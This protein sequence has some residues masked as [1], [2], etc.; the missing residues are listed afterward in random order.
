MSG[1][2][3]RAG[4]ARWCRWRGGGRRNRRRG[5]RGRS[6]GG[7]HGGATTAQAGQFILGRSGA[8]I[9]GLAIPFHRTIT[10]GADIEAKFIDQAKLV[11]R[12]GMALCA[13]EAEPA[14]C[15]RVGAAGTE[16]LRIDQAEFVFGFGDAKLGRR[17]GPE[18]SLCRIPRHPDAAI[19]AARRLMLSSTASVVR[20]GG[21]WLPGVSFS[22]RGT[23][24]S[25]RGMKEPPD[26]NCSVAVR[27]TIV[28]S[29]IPRGTPARRA[30][31]FAASRASG[32]TP[33]TLHGDDGFIRSY[34][35]SNFRSA[36]T[37]PV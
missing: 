21:R 16:P 7:R 29:Q 37:L 15:Q 9:G 18:E 36:K 8:G 10:I 28:E 35:A 4:H 6:G 5:D 33:F 31:I 11:Q 23:R 3:R 26:F 24:S 12:P 25:S 2:F 20:A 13:G 1:S 19:L 22:I 27:R 17:L 14:R 30:A 34:F 32:S